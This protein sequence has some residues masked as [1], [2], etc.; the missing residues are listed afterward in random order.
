MQS[1]SAA[2][3]PISARA[4]PSQGTAP[5]AAIR[6]VWRACEPR[7]SSRA[8]RPGTAW[9]RSSGGSPASTP[10][11]RASPSRPSRSR[12]SRAGA[13]ATS[14]SAS[15]RNREG[16][17]PFVFYEGPPTANGYPGSHHVLARV[18]KDVFP[19][20]KT[21]RGHYVERKAG[22][23]THGLPVE[24]AVEQQLGFKSKDD[25]ERYGIAEFNRQCR[26]AVFEHLADWRALTERIGLWVDLDD[27]YYTLDAE[28]H[29]VRLV[30]ARAD[31][32]ARPALRG[33]Q[34]RARTARAAARRSPR[35]RS[36]RATRTSRTRRLRALPGHA[37]GRRAARRRRAAGLDDDAVDAR[38]Q[39]RRRGRPGADLRAHAPAARCC[40]RGARRARAGRGRRDRRPLPGP[41]AA[42]RRL[43]AAVPVHPGRGLRREGPHRP[44]GRLRHRRGRHRHRAHG[45]RVRRGR[46]P[47]RRRAGP[48]RRQPGAARRHL[49]RA[50]RPV[51]RALGQGRRRRPDRGP[52]RARPAAARRDAPARL[53]A[54]LALRHAAALLRQAVLV[55]PHVGAA[56]PA[57]RRQRDG[58]PG[59]RRTSS[60]GAS[61]SGSRTTSTGRSRAS[62]TGARRCPSGAART[63][64]PSALGSLAEVRASARAASCRTRTG[65]TST[66]TPGRA[67]SAAARCAACPR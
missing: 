17:P 64:T 51:R 18:F 55:H 38:L 60:T 30:G 7:T 15:L 11:A 35:T 20:Y 9:L 12:C 57:A 58:R 4:M 3:T 5:A 42:R 19:R 13:S 32:G 59:T 65:P 50:H 23:D 37:A 26:E 2:P 1:T 52:A 67:P 56:R 61:A 31:V 28:L 33:P 6:A 53:P 27:A 34:G 63:A 66:S 47:A 21:M 14:S 49:R 48:R 22:W 46:L 54:L 62:A 40:A 10:A 43:R 24:I 29:R 36:R 25:I 8:G 44:A 45:D 39:R 41:R 16:A